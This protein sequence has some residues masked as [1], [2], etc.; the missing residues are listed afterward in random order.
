MGPRLAGACAA[1]AVAV[2]VSGCSGDAPGEEPSATESPSGTT[3]SRDAGS[4]GP[5]SVEPSPAPLDW[6]PTGGTAEDRRIVG[7]EW[8]ALVDARGREAA[9][10]GPAGEVRVPAGSGRIVSEVLMDDR[11]AVVVGQDE[12]EQRPSVVTVVDLSDGSTGPLGG[13]EPASGGSWSLHD[14]T[15]HY[16]TFATAGT[17]TSYCLAEV[18]IDQDADQDRDRDDARDV[19]WCAERRQGFTRL[20]DGPHGAALISFDDARPVACRTPALLVDRRPQPVP[21]AEDCSAWD[22]AATA[23]GAVWSQVRNE[24]RAE[25]GTFHAVAGGTTYDLGP[26]TTG[27]LTPCGDSAYFVRDPEGNDDHAQLLRWTPDAT[28]EV[29]YESESTGNAF[30]APPDCAGGVL[31][32]SAFG[33]QGDA[34]VTAPAP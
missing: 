19:V 31:T 33:E 20:T 23:D 17:G 18:D 32:V 4:D 21:Q 15:I 12:Q 10:S 11:W 2:L 7:P 34:Q 22:V 24:Q 30:L 14:G 3:T 25:A 26:G 9:F 27:T 29:V 1:V 13:P 8:T 28:L 5:V 6:K 16:G